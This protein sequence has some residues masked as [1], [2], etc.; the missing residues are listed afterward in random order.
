VLI[1]VGGLRQP[2]MDLIRGLVRLDRLRA[3]LPGVGKTG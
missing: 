1:L 3:R 2:D